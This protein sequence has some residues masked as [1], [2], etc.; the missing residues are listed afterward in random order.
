MIPLILVASLAVQAAPAE[1]PGALPGAST[2]VSVMVTLTEEPAS[3]VYARVKAASTLPAPEAA[4]AAKEASAAQALRVRQQQDRVMAALKR[5]PY[6]ATL[7]YR[8]DRHTNGIAVSIEARFLPQVRTLSGVKLA[9]LIQTDVPTA[10][11]RPVVGDAF[12][13]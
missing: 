2:T 12:R 5:P 9:Q 8:L 7:I 10:K 4:A 6:R 11:K 1:A 13:Y 3:R